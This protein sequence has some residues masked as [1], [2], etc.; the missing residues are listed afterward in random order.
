MIFGLL[1]IGSVASGKLHKPGSIFA[2]KDFCWRM[3][4]GKTILL[5]IQAQRS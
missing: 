5:D 1:L 2:S 3:L 4:I